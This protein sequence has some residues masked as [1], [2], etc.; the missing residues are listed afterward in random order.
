VLA[1]TRVHRARPEALFIAPYGVA[2]V[3]EDL[4]PPERAAAFTCPLYSG[5]SELADKVELR[6]LTWTLSDGASFSG[7][8]AIGKPT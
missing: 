4:D 8:V 5:S 2:H 7:I 3:R 1:H 6:T